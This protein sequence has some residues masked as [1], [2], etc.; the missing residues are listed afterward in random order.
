[1]AGTSRAAECVDPARSLPF[2]NPLK[3]NNQAASRSVSYFTVPNEAAM[4]WRMRVWLE[5]RVSQ[6]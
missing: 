5:F 4:E 3:N 6:Q 1:M 2:M